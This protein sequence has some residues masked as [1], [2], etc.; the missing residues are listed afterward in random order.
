MRRIF[1]LIGLLSLLASPAA[2]DWTG[3]D[4]AGATVTFFNA[5]TC[6]SV[7]CIPIAAL[8][9]AAG[10]TAYGTAGSANAAVLTV[11]GVA[12]MTPVAGNITQVL[13]AANSATNGLFVRTGSGQ[14]ASGSFASGSIGAGAVASGAM[15]DLGSQADA[16]CGSATGTCSV[17]A[18]LKYLNTA[19]NSALP[20]GTA[21]I[22][23]VES[24]V[25]VT[26]TDC[27]GTIATGGTAQN[28]FT[29]GATKH[30]FTIANLST[31]EP[32]W[33]S[34]TTTAA[35]NTVASYPLAAATATTFAGLS[36]Y[37]TPPG[38]GMNTALSVIGA[39][40]GTKFSCTWW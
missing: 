22:G 14:I 4:A 21:S 40:T 15:V 18:L 33:I 7:V 9:N 16:V 11:Q 36:S 34:F 26:P 29:A 23:K 25:N 13:G 30:G 6:T 32:I 12:S 3:K 8:V 1:G 27:S 17:V 39:T 19:A 2:A 28:A 5:G 31:S 24:S 37:S 20:A 10:A 38:F 35:A